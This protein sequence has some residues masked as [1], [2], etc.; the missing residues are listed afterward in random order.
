MELAIIKSHVR[1]SGASNH[2][3]FPLCKTPFG[4]LGRNAQEGSLEHD[5]DGE[6]GIAIC[7][8]FQHLKGLMLLFILLTFLSLP[9]FIIYGS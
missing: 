5:V 6:L 9:L 3:K 8:Y 7:V 4:W 2:E 1:Q